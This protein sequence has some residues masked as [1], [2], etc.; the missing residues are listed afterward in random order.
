MSAIVTHSFPVFYHFTLFY[1]YTVMPS[2]TSANGPAVTLLR[3]INWLRPFLK[4][5][6]AELRP[7]FGILVEVLEHPEDDASHTKTSDTQTKYQT[8]DKKREV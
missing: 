7:L 1:P 3:D 4:I 6:S 5:P 8:E 2:F